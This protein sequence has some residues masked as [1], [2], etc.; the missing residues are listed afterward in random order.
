MT[1]SKSGGAYMT[2]EDFLNEELSKYRIEVWDKVSP[3]NGKPAELFKSQPDYFEDGIVLL[4]YYNDQLA[5]FQPYHPFR[6]GPIREDELP[7]LIPQWLRVLAEPAARQQYEAY[8][9]EQIAMEEEQ[10]IQDIEEAIVYL[11]GG[12]KQ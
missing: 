5:F 6:G 1:I 10:R 2:F 9:Q 11:L 7:E 8:L 12:K 4:C 3:I